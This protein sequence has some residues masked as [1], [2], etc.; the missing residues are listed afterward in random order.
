MSSATNGSLGKTRLGRWY[1]S[2]EDRQMAWFMV[3]FDAVLWALSFAVG[4][5]TGAP[6]GLA[7]ITANV[8]AIIGNLSL[9]AYNMS[10]I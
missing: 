7:F 6:W 2:L 1:W 3:A 10:K 4:L 8:V 5:L 9:S